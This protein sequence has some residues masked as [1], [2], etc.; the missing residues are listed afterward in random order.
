MLGLLMRH[1]ASAHTASDG[2]GSP[3]AVGSVFFVWTVGPCGLAVS[4]AG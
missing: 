1:T 4:C 2:G 3:G